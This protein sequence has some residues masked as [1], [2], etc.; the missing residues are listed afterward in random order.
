MNIYSGDE[1]AS[2]K[3]TKTSLRENVE[4]YFLEKGLK[5]ITDT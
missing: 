2:Y 3:T 4:K 5:L 1:F